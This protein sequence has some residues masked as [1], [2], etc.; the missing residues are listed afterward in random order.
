[1]NKSKFHIYTIYIWIKR[2]QYDTTRTHT[3][4]DMRKR[5]SCRSTSTKFNT[6]QLL[7]KWKLLFSLI[8]TKMTILF[9]IRKWSIY[10]YPNRNKNNNKR[11]QSSIQNQHARTS[12]FSRS[13]ESKL[14]CRI[15]WDKSVTVTCPTNNNK[16]PQ[17]QQSRKQTRK[18]TCF[19]RLLANLTRDIFFFW[20]LYN[21]NETCWWRHCSR[22][23]DTDSETYSRLKIEE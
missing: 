5:K 1:M 18:D 2:I 11:S 17:S 9:E 22:T 6:I 13:I 8:N 21:R 15:N 7:L 16:H 4:Y 19:I 20:S 14:S 10:F 12:N 23:V 3:W